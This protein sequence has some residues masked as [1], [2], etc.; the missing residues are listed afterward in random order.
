MLT[1]ADIANV[2]GFMSPPWI[3]VADVTGRSAV[4]DRSRRNAA[5]QRAGAVWAPS[6]RRRNWCSLFR[7]APPGH[8]EIPSL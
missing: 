4:K 6:E 7:A 5:T 3:I 1:K 8:A 2:F